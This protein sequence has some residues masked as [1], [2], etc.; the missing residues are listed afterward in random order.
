MDVVV[1]RLGAQQFGI[2][3]AHVSQV[4][5][6][7]E[8]APLSGATVPV[9]GTIDLHGELTPVVD[10]GHRVA[11]AWTEL[12]LEQQFILVTGP[13]RRVVLL[14]DEVEGVQSIADGAL[15][16]ATDLLDG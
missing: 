2:P 10:L 11:H 7:A 16:L 13:T 14:A 15:V 8:I 3:L 1:F 9:R 6:V 12:R 4:F 5:P